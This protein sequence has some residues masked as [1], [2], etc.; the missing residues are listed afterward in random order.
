MLLILK[1]GN[2]SLYNGVFYD[3][4]LKIYIYVL[5]AKYVI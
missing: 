5:V 4:L 1:R 3:K 2:Y